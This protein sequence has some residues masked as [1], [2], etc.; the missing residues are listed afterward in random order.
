MFTQVYFHKTRVAYDYHLKQAMLTILPNGQFPTLNGESL[1]DYLKWDDWRVL[2]ELAAGGGGEHGK[3]LADRN[4][5][6]EI[7]HT[8]EIP[9][10]D[11]LRRF[12]EIRQNLGEMARAVENAGKSWYKLENDQDIPIQSDNANREIRPLSEH[13]AA[14]KGLRSTGRRMLYCREEEKQAA[15]NVIHRMESAT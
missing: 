14:V 7:H 5:F 4:H 6:R 10:A 9:T 1:S 15:M 3:R 11:D 2:G 13:S 12:D 8:P